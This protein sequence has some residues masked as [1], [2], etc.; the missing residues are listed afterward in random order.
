MRERPL[1]TS[2]I[3]VGRGVQDSPPNGTLQSRTR[4]V[5]RSKM[6]KK[7]GTSL[8]DVPEFKL[9]LNFG[10]YYFLNQ[11]YLLKIIVYLHIQTLHISYHAS[12]WC[13]AYNSAKYL[14]SQNYFPTRKQIACAIKIPPYSMTH[15]SQNSFNKWTKISSLEID[16]FDLKMMMKSGLDI[17]LIQ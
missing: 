2:N 9:K 11:G 10:T 7:R 8:M 15:T 16:I 14:R 5:G 13:N 6:A 3:R 4:Q 12:A 17:F 1:M